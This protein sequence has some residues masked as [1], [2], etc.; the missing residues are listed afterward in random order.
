MPQPL[1]FTATLIDDNRV[2]FLAHFAAPDAD[3]PGPDCAPAHLE[4]GDGITV[5]LG[6][7]CPP[8]KVTW[9][10]A[11]TLDLGAH[12]YTDPT[13]AAQAR[14]IWGKITIPVEEVGTRS[15]APSVEVA[16][17]LVQPDPA[18]MQVR[19]KLK[20]AGLVGDQAV[21]VDGDLGQTSIIRA[22]ADGAQSHEWLFGYPKPGDYRV[23]VD[24]LDG[25]GFPVARLGESPVQMAEPVDFPAS[26]PAA[27]KQPFGTL[28]SPVDETDSAMLS[29][30]AVAAQISPE[31]MEIASAAGIPWLPFRYAY[32]LW[33][34]ART[35]TAPGGSN[36]SRSLAHG[37]Y[38]AVRTE[39]SVGGQIWY[40]TGSYDWIPASSVNLFVTSELRGVELGVD[41][42]PD[43]VTTPAPP[44]APTPT[45]TPTPTPQPI[46]RGTVTANRLNV[47]A[48]PGTGANNPVVAQVTLGTTVDI[49]EERSV[50]GALW[51]RIGVNRWV[52]SGW[53]RITE[54]VDPTPA[55]AP[56]PAPGPTP[57][58]QPINHGRVTANRLNVRAQPGARS[59]N[60]AI[61]QVTLNSVVEIWGEQNY[62]GA[63]WYRIGPGA[64]RDRWVHSGYVTIIPA[65]RSVVA[66]PAVQAPVSIAANRDPGPVSLPLGWVTSSS[67]LNV[68]SQ[69]GTSG[70]TVGQVNKYDRLPILE[71]R[72]VAGAAWHRIGQDRWVYGGY[73]GVA[74]H[75]PRPSGIG[76]SERW[77]S[78]CLSEQTVVAY[79]GDTPVYA[80]LA[81]TGLPG[82]PTVQGTFRTYWRVASRRMTGGTP[83]TS[84]YYYIE[85][86][87]WTCYFYGGYAL[88]T[89]YW[90]DAFGSPRS[91]GCVN[92]S[93]YDAWWI[94][95]WSGAGG[96][97]SPVVHVYWA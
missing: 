76:A 50:A 28:D 88:H 68:R 66:A 79:E 39:T 38:L 95:Q 80:C 13:L 78:V 77:V 69:P 44:P 17:F 10:A 90:Q 18:A 58:P 61:D 54:T 57:D 49:F 73:V 25:K 82:T 14:L 72:T 32:P 19:V 48:Q 86:V 11:H 9:A 85:E 33:A 35:Y 29:T 53:V 52:H 92:M 67:V 40:Q 45:P 24:L 37:T 41:P 30:L 2:Q 21:R 75:R 55:P 43:P 27:A 42:A 63:V 87:T 7:L 5:N 62:L 46:K 94:F 4:T 23:T 93:P 1:R 22:G 31:S 15:V 16:T 8:S 84:A 34:W 89:A 70:S 74:R 36:V 3:P 59:D 81:A 60:P 71:S 91:H 51:Y 64:N 96:A 12:S 56:D 83:G 65:T 26:V 47:R 20:V 6:L 97:T